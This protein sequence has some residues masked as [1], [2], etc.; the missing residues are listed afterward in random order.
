MRVLLTGSSGWLGQFLAPRLRAAG[1]AAVGLDIAP[2]ADTH[3]VGSVADRA[4]V[5]RAF[6]TH[7]IEAVVHTGALHKPDIAR[8][9]KTAFIDANVTGT[10]N[11]LEAAVAACHDRFVFTSTTSLMISQGIRQETASSAVWL[12]ESLGPL[13]PRNIYGV[14]KLAAEGLCRLHFLEFGLNCVV[15]RTGRFFPE[16]DDTQRGLSGPNLKANEFLN[17]RL[18]VEDAADAHVVALDR[19]PA[20]GFEIF[21]LSAPTPFVRSEAE[22]LKRAAADV[23]ERHFPDASAL[24]ARRG[25]R[26]P[27]SIGRVYDASRIER[28]MGFRCATDFGRVLQALRTDGRLPYCHEPTYQSPKEGPAVS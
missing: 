25:W 12:D 14:T 4:V 20:L 16:E 6:S 2:G 26:L 17:R 9:P 24:Y 13:A 10:L 27:T 18:T 11:L 23:I 22:A 3:V 8:Y 28:V 5:E 19:A 15:L 7:G 1:H 21:V